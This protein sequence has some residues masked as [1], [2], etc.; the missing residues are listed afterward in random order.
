MAVEKIINLKV[1]D[2]IKD[3]ENNVVSLKRQLR[4]AQQD[5]QNLADKFGATSREAVQAAKK[6]AELKDR[7]GDA[8]TLTDA[9]NPDAKFRSLSASIGGVASAFSAYQG[10]LSIA[11]V[12]SKDLQEQLLRVQGAMALSQGLQGIG[13]ARDSFKQLGA[14]I[15]STAVKLGILTVTKQLDTVATAV[16][17]TAT[18]GQVVANQLAATSF[19]ATGVAAKTSLNGIKGAL[20]AT[21]IGLLVI[22]LGTIVAYWDDIKGAVNGVSSEQK[23]LNQLAEKNV[24]TANEN[25]DA[26]KS[27]DNTLKLQGKSE[28]EILDIKIKATQEAINANIKR[29]NGLLL[30]NKLEAEAAQRNYERLKSFLDFVSI[31][32]RILFENAATAINKVI[33][34]VNKIPGV[35]IKG[36]IDEKFVSKA[37]D[38]MTKLVFDP[39]KTKAEG[40]A[41]LK[42]TQKAIRDL[43]NERDGYTNEKNKKDDKD[44][45]KTEDKTKE[46]LDALANLEKKYAEDIENLG[47]KTEEDKLET[48]K[49]RALAELEAIKL[50]D[51]EKA[52]AKLLIEQDFQLKDEALK[53]AHA[54][55]ILALTNKLEEDKNALIIKSDEEKLLASQEKAMKQL[56]LELQNANASTSEIESAKQTLQETF[57]SQNIALEDAQWLREQEAT[58]GKNEYDALTRQ[59]KYEAEYIAAQGN[60]ELQLALKNEY[61]KKEEE[62]EKANGEAIKKIEEEKAA[63]KAKALSAISSGLKTAASL[64]GES[65]AAGKA[66]AIAATTIDTIQ[67]GVSAFKGMTA[68]VPGPV[69]IGLGVV[70]A[71]GALASGYASVKK[72]LAVKT[73]G[74]GGGSAGSVGA[75]PAPPSF[76]IVGQNSTNQL[77]QTI[78]GQQQQP[79]QAYVVSGNISSAQS[80]DRNRIDTATFN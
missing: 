79:L 2:D 55:K 53:K 6:A 16:N 63:A 49:K 31:P 32:Q 7:I 14:T 37:N 17:T 43:T 9:F 60:D 68:A 50:S 69:G 8:K 67:S 61:L 78:A 70:A 57:D 73:P 54:E 58:L 25:L 75:A 80:L 24:K 76:N 47:D 10:A 30:T 11:G 41:N 52:N 26:A 28:K 51:A 44:S 46:H 66:A 64:L 77:A 33:D 35:E 29:A 5:V 65:T 12:E 15:T 13:E 3:T 36:R 45:Q 59:L 62:S 23:K 1:N 39:D 27:T 71:A 18:E 21:G 56:E 74:G 20:A 34:L 4:E 38:Y 72:I 40:A 22:A 48:Q 42:E 19:T